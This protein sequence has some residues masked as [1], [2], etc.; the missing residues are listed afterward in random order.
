MSRNNASISRNNEIAGKKK[1]RKNQEFL[2]NLREIAFEFRASMWN[3]K[4]ILYNFYSKRKEIFAQLLCDFREKKYFNWKHQLK[5]TVVV[6]SC[7]TSFKKGMS[8]SQQYTTN[9]FMWRISLFYVMNLK[10][11]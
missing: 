1:I 4:E 2:Q 5:G 6:I 11:V 10:S 9:I 3:Y 7:D 8:D